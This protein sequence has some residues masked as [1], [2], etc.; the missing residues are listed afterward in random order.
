MWNTV[1]ELFQN[2]MGA[3]LIVTWFL[4]CMIYL[5]LKEEDKGRRILFLY[6]PVIMLLLFFNPI[7][8]RV[9]YGFIGSEIY[10][11]I[12]WLIPITVVIAYTVV[13]VYGKLQGKKAI[14]FLGVAAVL[15]ITS[16]SCIYQNQ[17]FY[18]AENIYHMPQAVVNICDQIEVEGREV[19]AVFPQELVP[20]VRQYSPVVCMPYGR[21]MLVARWNFRNELYDAMEAPVVDVERIATLTKQYAC[22]FVIVKKEKE[23]Q[24]SF[25]DFDYILFGET[26]GY[27]IYQD[28]TVY[29]GL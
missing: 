15:T 2:Y 29:I 9:I 10:Y 1:I 14:V 28:T 8:M 25:E 6:V 17:F 3:G 27:I 7:F 23:L 4:V 20:F 16:G 22:H 18:K 26:D 19:M 12:L 5:F 11:R 24:G 21:E 13:S